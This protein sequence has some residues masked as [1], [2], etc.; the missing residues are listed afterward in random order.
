M[1][2]IIYTDFDGVWTD[3]TV[4]SDMFGNELVKCNKSDSLYLSLF[5]KKI[6]ELSLDIRIVVVTSE[7]NLCVAKRCEKLGLEIIQTS[8]DK[9]IALKKY[10]QKEILNCSKF[11]SFYIGNDLNDLTAMQ[12]C[13][14]TFCPS[15]SADE[16]K[17]QVDR[18]L[19]S[20]G[21]SGVIREFIM[22]YCKTNSLDLF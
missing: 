6:D 19:D 8:L 2:H 21:G 16:V 18:V 4:L 17:K 12:I 1:K 3:N 15:D 14:Y 22:W 5:K 10:Q 20:A 9:Q 11:E 13:N 7:L